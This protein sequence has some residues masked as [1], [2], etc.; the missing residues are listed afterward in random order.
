VAAGTGAIAADAK[1][2]E[3]LVRP[4]TGALRGIVL[5]SPDEQL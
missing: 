5:V 3:A 4:A 1:I 2:K